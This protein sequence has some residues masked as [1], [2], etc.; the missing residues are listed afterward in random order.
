VEGTVEKEEKKDHER[1]IS[2]KAQLPECS[3][4]DADHDRICSMRSFTF[5]RSTDMTKHFPD[6]SNG[7]YYPKTLRAASY[8]G[9]DASAEKK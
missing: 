3:L 7:K 5:T 2:E 1:S 8:P 9:S 4:T 6:N